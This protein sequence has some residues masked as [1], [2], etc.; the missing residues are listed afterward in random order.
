MANNMQGGM[1]GGKKGLAVPATPSAQDE[2]TRL[3]RAQLGRDPDQAGL[4]WWTQ[5]ANSGAVTLDAIRQNFQTVRAEGTDP[6]RGSPPPANMTYGEARNQAAL[7]DNLDAAGKENWA[8]SHM[9]SPVAP[10]PP[11]PVAY[12]PPPPPSAAQATPQATA[13]PR[14]GSENNWNLPQTGQTLQQ[15][16]DF[17]AGLAAKGVDITAPDFYKN[18]EWQAYMAADREALAPVFA[19][20]QRQY[21]DQ[22]FVGPSNWRD[23][24]PYNPQT[25]GGQSQQPSPQQPSP[26]RPMQPQQPMQPSSFQ[27]PDPVRPVRYDL[28]FTGLGDPNIERQRVEDA[29]YARM[30]PQLDRGRAALETRLANQG[31]TQGSEA[32]RTAIDENNRAANDARIAAILSGGQEQSRLFGL[33]LNQAQFQNQGQNQEFS[34]GL[35][36]AQLN[37]ATSAQ[38]F[39]QALA[40]AQFQNQANQAAISQALMERQI[41]LNEIIALM[42]GSQVQ[43]PNFVNTAQTPVQGTDISGNIYANYQGAVNQYNQRIA[44][45]NAMLGGLFGLGGTLGGAYLLR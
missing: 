14:P 21:E 6:L 26:Q 43:P 45:Q 28:D 20:Q 13:L 40:E 31:I 37:N 7:M 39:N 27:Q 38:A 41:P 23:T 29:I 12:A 24:D 5:Q 42:S 22:G 11:P 8:R 2:I 4:D 33:G 16:R 1:F 34:Q 32:Y 9:G 18:P 17:T 36:N 15:M 30:N 35:A 10:P 25:P 44:Q 3:Y 19:A